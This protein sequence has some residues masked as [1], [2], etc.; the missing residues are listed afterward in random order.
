MVDEAGSRVRMQLDSL[1]E[2]IDKLERKIL[3]LDI[4]RAALKKSRSSF[5]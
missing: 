2:G 1:P 3:T 4:E 5:C